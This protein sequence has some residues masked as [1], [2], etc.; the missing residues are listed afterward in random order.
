MKDHRTTPAPELAA[1][2]YA[3][4]Q[5]SSAKAH[6]NATRPWFKKK[7]VVI[8]LSLI[9]LIVFTA[10]V[11]LRGGVATFGSVTG[12]SQPKVESA[13]QGEARIAGIGTKV[14]DGTFEFVVTGVER[15]GKTLMGK[16]DETL[17]AHGEFVIVRVN[18]TNVGNRAQSPDCSCQLLHNDEGREFEPS[19]AILS[20]KG[21]L[22][23]VRQINPGDTVKDVLVLFDVAPGTKIVDVELHDSPFSTGA[24]VKLF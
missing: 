3:V 4:S 9:L 8:P 7:H 18:V 2:K 24:K 5:A 6:R 23:F 14:H 10:A 12:G 20:T 17:T 16:L 13:P 11:N 19:P 1:P 15:P 22:K 21:A